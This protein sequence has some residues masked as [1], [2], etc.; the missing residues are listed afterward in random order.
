MTMT[1][2]AGPVDTL[3]RALAKPQLDASD[4]ALRLH[5]LLKTIEDYQSALSARR[6]PRDSPPHTSAL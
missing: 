4:A 6:G 2:L 3:C 5:E 1:T